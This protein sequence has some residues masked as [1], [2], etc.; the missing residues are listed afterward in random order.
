MGATPYQ[1]ISWSD[2]EPVYMDKLNAMANNDQW[3]FENAPNMYYNVQG[4]KKTTGVKIMTGF[5]YIPVTTSYTVRNSV[6][7]FYFGSFFS[8]GCLPVVVA[9]LQTYPQT[10]IAISTR[11]IG[12]FWPDQR[13]FECRAAAVDS[14]ML[15]QT[16]NPNVWAAFI[17][18][19]W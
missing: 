16:I 12:T 11:G 9:S 10:R 17:A 5:C 2:N 19:G 4:I 1:P 6:A 3:L 8:Q 14:N 13:G 15:W 7:T 18:V